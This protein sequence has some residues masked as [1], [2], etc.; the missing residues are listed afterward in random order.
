M[1]FTLSLTM[2][3]PVLQLQ[4]QD[5]VLLTG[6]CFTEHMS[7]R[8]ASGKMRIVANPHG[9]LFNPLSVVQSLNTYIDKKIYTAADLFCL[10]EIWHS[11]DFHSRFSHTDQDTALSLMNHSVQ[12]AGA[13]LRQTQ[14]LVI[15]LGSAFQ[16]FTNQG[17]EGAAT[18]GVANCHRAPAGWFEKKLLPVADIVLEFK[19]VLQRLKEIN[20]ALQVLFTI[21]PVRHVRDGVIENNR[22]KARLIEAV[23]QLAEEEE[24]CSYFPAYE[25]VVDVLRDYRFYDSDMV[26]PNYIATQYVW[27]QFAHHWIAPEAHQPLSAFQDIQVARQHKVRFPDTREHRKFCADYLQK[28]DRLAALYPYVDLSEERA[29]FFRTSG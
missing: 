12:E 2:K 17:Q 7:S 22:S 24:Q 27:D 3:K 14:W 11:W 6:S 8:M 15:T 5:R 13:F 25:M 18:R 28:I 26:H 16:Y 1:N 19:E 29:Y 10:H 4:H 20:P 21:S 23:H 9:I